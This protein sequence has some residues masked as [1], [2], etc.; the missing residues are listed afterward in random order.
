MILNARLFEEQKRKMSRSFNDSLALFILRFSGKLSKFSADWTELMLMSLYVLHVKL[1][2]V[3]LNTTVWNFPLVMNFQYLKCQLK[4]A[5]WYSG[6][7]R[8]MIPCMQSWSASGWELCLSII[9]CY[10]ILHLIGVCWTAL[11]FY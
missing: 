10:K 2:Y 9:R 11:S 4:A 3:C 5:L 8:P 7:C 1:T 6:S